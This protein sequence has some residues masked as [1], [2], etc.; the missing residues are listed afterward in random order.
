MAASTLSR[1]ALV[2]AAVDITRNEGLSGVTMRAVA[3][4]F[5]VTAMA[6]YRHVADREELVRLVA[7]HLGGLVRPQAP[8]GASWED[9]AHAWATAQ[10]EVL[11][12]YPGVAAWLIDNGPAGP[13][14]YRLLDLLVGVLSDAGF[15]DATVARGASAIMSWTFTRV[16]IEDSADVRIRRRAPNRTAAFLDGLSG[17]DTTTHQAATR[18]GPEFFTLPLSEIFEAGLDLILAGLRSKREG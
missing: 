11:R 10:R 13:A 1:D 14:A 5:D 18:V 7:D 12:Q 3:A 2:A 9:R 17:I 8:A 15:D 16:A 4:R 6:L